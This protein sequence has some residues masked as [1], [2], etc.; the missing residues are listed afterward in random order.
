PDGGLVL[1]SSIS[2]R[3]EPRAAVTVR[4]EA[5]ARLRQPVSDVGLRLRTSCAI[6]TA[7]TASKIKCGLN[8]ARRSTGHRGNGS[9]PATTQPSISQTN[10]WQAALVL[11]LKSDMPAASAR[12]LTAGRLA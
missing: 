11:E 10:A 3:E 12:I 6:A 1:L 9:K 8:S 5:N 4:I 2:A 7:S